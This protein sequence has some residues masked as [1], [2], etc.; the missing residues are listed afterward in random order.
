MNAR[1][2][3]GFYFILFIVISMGLAAAA[4][5]PQQ[6]KET[7]KKYIK[8]SHTFHIDDLG[9]DCVDCH[10]AVETSAAASD[11]NLAHKDDCY[12]CHDGDAAGNECELC[13]Y[14][15]DNA[16]DFPNPARE[17]LFNHQHHITLV[18]EDGESCT[19]C[20]GGLE[21]V[22]YA[23]D[24]NMPAMAACAACHDN[25]DAAQYCE[26][27]HTKLPALRPKSHN[28]VWIQRHDDAVR[29]TSEDCA[30]CHSFNYCQEC[31]DGARLA[32]ITAGV[33]DKIT[34]YAVQ[35]W[36]V[37]NLILSRNHGLNYRYTHALEAK[38]KIERCQLCHETEDFCV[39]CHQSAFET[40]KPQ[41]HG[42]ADWG[43]IAY[44]RGTG[45]GRHAQMAKRDI[46][47]CAS[48]HDANG[49]DPACLLCHMDRTPG[50]N[51][52]LRTHSNNLYKGVRGA[53][54]GDDSYVCFTC[55]INANRKD[56]SGFC[57]YCHGIR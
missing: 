13:H 34:P 2:R 52:D 53:W 37:R 29:S 41:W 25:T 28:T 9:V 49:E 57:A 39:S 19:K 12:A 32:G 48:C 8:F 14:D 21:N 35:N 38:S 6:Q 5:A 23:T 47:M 27:C 7:R 15:P 46:A 43:A 54:H 3:S 4:A 31:H 10:S 17:I 18:E 51:N 50:R 36:G 16:V 44:G 55:H 42:G 33:S 45:G 26:S 40:G 1:N 11:N 30:L 56:P 22:D 20:H 24:E